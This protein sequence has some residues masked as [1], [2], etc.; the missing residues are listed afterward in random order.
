MLELNT[1]IYD[2]DQFFQSRMHDMALSNTFNTSP[3]PAAHDMRNAALTGNLAVLETSITD[4]GTDPNAVHFRGSEK[5]DITP[6]IV[7]AAGAGQSRT[8][9]RLLA[10][11]RTDPN[12]T[13]LFGRSAL[14]EAMFNN[15][16]GIVRTLVNDKRTDLAP[17]LEDGNERFLHDVVLYERENVAGI[18]G[19]HPEHGKAILERLQEFAGIMN[20]DHMVEFCAAELSAQERKRKEHTA[21]KPH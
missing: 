4:N 12:Q 17:L 10:D 3:D 8:V 6:A 1:R 16:S 7:L 21:P 18:L 11:E 15:E 2:S 5:V 13:D 19:G 14:M 20:N 9:T